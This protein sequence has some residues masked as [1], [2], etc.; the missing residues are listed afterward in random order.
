MIIIKTIKHIIQS[1]TLQCTKLTIPLKCSLLS[2][3]IKLF[4][5][6]CCGIEFYFFFKNSI[7]AIFYVQIF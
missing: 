4:K 7:I 5:V 6:I 3:G 1:C 2:T